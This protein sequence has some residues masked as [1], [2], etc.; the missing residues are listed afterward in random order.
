[1]KIR[2]DFVTNSSSSSFILE[3][4]ISLKNGDYVSFEA[5]GGTPECGR[6]DYF[7]A[8]AIVTV[9]PKQ[10][11]ESESVNEMIRKLQEGVLDDDWNPHPIF[12]EPR[13]YKSDS[14]GWGDMPDEYFNAYD[15]IDDIKANIHSMDDIESISIVG[16][17]YNYENY[18]REFTYDMDSHAYVGVVSGDYIE[19]DGSHG[20]DLRFN[21]L[22]DCDIKFTDT[23]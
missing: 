17:E 10:L 13:S 20:G 14:S 19:C 21:D 6:E 16:N 23:E 8:D 15:F 22:K 2:T 4:N 3:I 12:D 11:G 5:N 9:S 7:D 1:M 18:L